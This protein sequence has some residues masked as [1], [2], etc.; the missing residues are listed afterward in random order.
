MIGQI[1]GNIN[2][3]LEFLIFFYVIFCREYRKSKRKTRV[4]LFLCIVTWLSV[5]AMGVDLYG[6]FIYLLFGFIWLFG[7]CLK[8]PSQSLLLGALEN[9]T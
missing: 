9:G 5:I 7:A 6:D 1:Q 2:M 3:L 8:F 4:G